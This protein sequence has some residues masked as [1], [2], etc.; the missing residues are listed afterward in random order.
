M[1]KWFFLIGFV[2]SVFYA[3]PTLSVEQLE[4][5]LLSKYLEGVEVGIE[6]YCLT[7]QE[8]LYSK[9]A[10]KLL[11]VASNNKLVTTFSALEILGRRFVHRTELKAVGEIQNGIL[12]GDLVVVGHGDP[13]ISGRFYSSPLAI[14]QT[15]AKA[16]K[17]QG[18]H[19][20]EGNLLAEDQ[21]FDREWISPHWPKDQ[22]LSWYSAP[23]SALSFNDNCIIISV[24]PG[25]AGEVHL[26]TDP[27][28]RFMT[29]QNQM[30]V[31]PNGKTNF[32]VDRKWGTNE[33]YARG[34]FALTSRKQEAEITIHDPS[35]FLLT[36]F[37]E[38]L[39]AENIKLTGTLGMESNP[40]TGK[41]LHCTSHPL[42]KTLST[43]NKNSQNFYAEHLFKIL[44][45][46]CFGKG[47]F[48][49]GAK[50]I[51]DLLKKK[52]YQEFEVTDGSG[53]SR[54]NRYSSHL[55]VGLLK[56]IYGHPDRDF[57]VATLPVSGVDGSMKERLGSSYKKRVRAKTGYIYNVSA[58]SGFVR[59]RSDKVYAFSFLMNGFATGKNPASNSTMK[60]I[61]DQ[62]L[63]AVI[64][65]Y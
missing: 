17:K 5:I 48:E 24:S 11:S 41:M 32:W 50:A 13:N 35:L 6:I 30:K 19:T 14:P 49:N 12:N 26:Q 58:L 56:D 52:G 38:S 61:Q 54:G 65:Y 39:E 46:H 51:S 18:I 33:V 59:S 10:E 62:L 53:L 55:L 60:Q 3:S 25:S 57:F 20:I 64:D 45:K 34:N 42:F 44:G 36:V 21:D 8:L 47:T 31:T 27:P 63:K 37:Q 43:I 28:T 29:L 23:V 7:N 1:R 40:R 9:N 22:L 15:W 2:S 16:L 4:Q